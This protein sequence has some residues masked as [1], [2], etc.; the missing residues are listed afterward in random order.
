MFRKRQRALPSASTTSALFVVLD[1]IAAKRRR[2]FR[3]TSVD[4]RCDDMAGRWVFNNRVMCDC[5]RTIA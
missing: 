5:G 3:N 4:N 2:W 1:F